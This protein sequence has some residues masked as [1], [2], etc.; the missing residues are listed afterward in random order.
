MKK[1]YTTIEEV[2]ASKDDNTIEFIASKEV[3]DR[4]REIVSIKGIDLK[5]YKKN[6]VVLFSHQRGELPIGKAVGITKSGDSLKM[7]VEF[8]DEA[9]YPF[10][11]QVYKLI[12]GGY[13]NAV[14]IGFS[15]DYDSITYDEKKNTRTFNKVELFEV[16]VVTVPA[17]ADALATGKSI[18]ETINKAFK[19]EVIT[20]DELKEWDEYIEEEDSDD[21]AELI[22]SLEERIE[23]LE[24]KLIDFDTK[25]QDTDSYFEDILKEFKSAGG[26]SDD[27][28]DAEAKILDNLLDILKSDE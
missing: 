28:P 23:A 6:P 10:A 17:N 11:H 13:L 20:E 2:K 3:A 27:E 15:P 25:E 22:K 12:K 19:D 7:K 4:D 26:S 9:T 24:E 8:A 14:S 16:S 1:F 21:T 18:N 5:N